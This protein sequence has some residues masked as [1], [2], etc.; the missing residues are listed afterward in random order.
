MYQLT[1]IVLMCALFVNMHFK[2]FKPAGGAKVEIG[3]FAVIGHPIGH[4]MSPFIHARLFKYSGFSPDYAVLDI[5]DLPAA[6]DRLR[7]LDGFNITI[8]H[9]TSILPLLDAVEEHAALFGSVNTVKNEGGRLTGYTTDGAGCKKAL[10][11]CGV[12]LSGRLLLL[13]NGG[14]ARAVA[15]EAL[16]SGEVSVLDIACRAESADKAEALQAAL[17]ALCASRGHSVRIRVLP[18]AALERETAQYDLLL[19]TTSVGMHPKTGESPVS[20]AVVSR[21]G[22]VFDAVYNP[23]E[24]AL[25]RLSREAGRKTVGGMGMLVCQA[26]AAH[27]IWY[28][29]DFADAA[30]EAL[31]LDAEKETERLFHG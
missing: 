10:L 24:T 15:F 30:I 25:L 3:C 23:G 14:A 4:T 7:A 16:L 9:K 18:Y 6:A 2:F 20:A 12:M 21:V 26:V 13:G 1:Y 17:S 5:P 31:I 29:A 28:N 27:E 11:R 19:N 22:A 8:P